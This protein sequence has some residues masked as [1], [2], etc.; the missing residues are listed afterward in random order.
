MIFSIH[1]K[2]EREKKQ[3]EKNKRNRKASTIGKD[4][5]QYL[6]ERKTDERNTKKVMK[7]ENENRNTKQITSSYHS[8]G[9]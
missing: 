6:N 8:L 4:K 3:E 2:R 9:V 1:E 7:I 5:Q